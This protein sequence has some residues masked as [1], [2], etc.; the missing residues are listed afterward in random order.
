MLNIPRETHK[1]LIEPLSE[2]KHISSVIYQRFLN[3]IQQINKSSKKLPKKL[4][5]VLKHD[6]SSV[7]G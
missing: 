2:T 1:Y 3:F 7:T 6:V 5:K 4:L